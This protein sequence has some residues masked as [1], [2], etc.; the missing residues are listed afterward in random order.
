M[1]VGVTALWAIV[2]TYSQSPRETSPLSYYFPPVRIT[3]KTPPAPT[4]GYTSK[5]LLKC[6]LEN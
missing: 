2:S 6:I 1:D 3:T 4:H 5:H